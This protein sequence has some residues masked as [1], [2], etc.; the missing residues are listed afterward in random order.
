MPGVL[1]LS[2]L[3][4]S[5]SR[6]LIPLVSLQPESLAVGVLASYAMFWFQATGWSY[7]LHPAVGFGILL[8]STVMVL[9]TE[10]GITPVGPRVQAILRV[11]LYGVVCITI[12]V[13]TAY[14]NIRKL[15]N[16][17]GVPEWKRLCELIEERSAPNEPVAFISLASPYPAMAYVDRLPGTRY[18]VGWPLLFL[19][20][21]VCRSS[22]GSFPYRKQSEMT[23]E[24]RLILK[25]IGN[26][27]RSRAPRLIFIDRSQTKTGFSVNH[28]LR[29]T[30]WLGRLTRGYV[31]I[32]SYKVWDV[33]RH[34]D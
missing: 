34:S 2:L 9:A 1:V 19:Y 17:H 6:K 16:V 10:K 32:A 29:T 5:C 28:F 20:N 26:D 18:L 7:Q 13:A 27:I 12:V 33:Y 23:S 15:R 31:W 24:E 21:G 4:L 25:D 3:V 14:V 11:C 8:V 22:N 30:G